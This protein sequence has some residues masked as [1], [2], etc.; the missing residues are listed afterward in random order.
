MTALQTTSDQATAPAII[1]SNSTT[2]N[3]GTDAHL[4]DLV[5]RAIA[6]RA[7]HDR[8]DDRA[9]EA[10]LR[11]YNAMWAATEEA[12]TTPARTMEGLQ[13]KARLFKANLDYYGSDYGPNYVHFDGFMRGL[14]A[15][16]ER[17][18]GGVS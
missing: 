13:A 15:D 4:I 7:E 10:D 17:L 14:I 11:I 16:I 8:L 9:H 18:A 1:S 6:L 5:G 2:G 3:T 12:V